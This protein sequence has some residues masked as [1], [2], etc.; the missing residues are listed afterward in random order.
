MIGPLRLSAAEQRLIPGGRFAGPTPWLIAIMMFVTVIVAGA[1]LAMANSASNVSSSVGQ[2]YS[3]E[4]SSAATLATAAR[5][6]QAAPGVRS[7]AIVDERE[8][9]QLLE[10]WLGSGASAPGLPL[11]HLADVALTPGADAAGLRAAV[12]A[13]APGVRLVPHRTLAAPLVR[14]IQ[15]I[16]VVALAI[17][18][19]MGLA[20][21]AAVVLATRGALDTNR[22]TI[23]LMHGMGATDTQISRLFMHRIALDALAGGLAG[24]AAAA[25][26]FAALVAVGAGFVADLAGTALLGPGDLAILALLPLG[27]VAL[28]M[29]VARQAVLGALRERL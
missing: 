15:L 17:V 12:S 2:R 14:T 13:A 26:V 21:A 20:S 28:A 3:I 19:M 22:S 23:E 4:A 7:V 29:L 25:L 5:A 16:G 9:R 6:A 18:V 11:P 27:G 8:L 1:G 10:R 24:A